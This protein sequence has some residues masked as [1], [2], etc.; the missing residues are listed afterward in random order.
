MKATILG[1]LNEVAQQ[2]NVRILYACES[3]SRAWGFASP[4]SDYDVRFIYS[5]PVEQY[6]RLS[7]PRDV[8]EIPIQDDLDVSGWDLFKACRLLRR[9][10]PPILEWLNSPIVYLE[11]GEFVRELR[12]QAGEHFSRR[13][14]CE[15]YLSSAR[16]NWQRYVVGPTA[17]TLKKFLYV[18][19]PLFAV[20]W[21]LAHNTFPPTA[22]PTTL[23]GISLPVD[24]RQSVDRLLASKRVSR[25]AATA[26]IDRFLIG[27]AERGMEELTSRVAQLPSTPFPEVG[28]NELLCRT[29]FPLRK[30]IAGLS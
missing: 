27:H 7:P 1:K 4:D 11:D 3:G 8:I 13:G 19:R 15:H 2:H 12:C 5:R 10:N 25:E 20:E 9:S 22:F 28:L 30:T 14:C 29:L 24:V 16:S 26:P 18:L 6:L 23:E 21:I 17:G